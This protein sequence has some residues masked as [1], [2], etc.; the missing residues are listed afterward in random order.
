MICETSGA[1]PNNV[2]GTLIP[3]DYVNG[4]KTAEITNILIPGEE[5]ETDDDL[6]ERYY[7]ALNSQA[8]GGNIA[9]YI[10]KT[11]EIDGVGGVKVTPVWNGGGTVKLTVIASDFSVPTDTLIDTVQ[12]IMDPVQN[13]GIGK[14]LAPIGHVVTV[15]GVKAKIINIE[16]KI[17]YQDGWSY[18]ASE[19]YIE[20][21]VDAYFLE[22]SKE[23]DL[24]DSLIV[25]VSAI[26]TRIL[27]CAGILDIADT[28]L[29]GLAGNLQLDSNCIPVRGD[30]VG[31]A[32]D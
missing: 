21:A 29:N 1:G 27:A 12:T 17:T 32:S 8:F 9:D 4:L 30:I 13:Q 31:Q 6:R 26:E 5:K 3:I 23:W 20:K 28:M 25:R 7:S 2:S 10:E 19:S 14:G 16:A 24:S 18:E 15:E 22:L 11:N